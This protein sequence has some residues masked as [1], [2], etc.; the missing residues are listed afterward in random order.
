[1]RLLWGPLLAGVGPVGHGVRATGREVAKAD[2]R[3]GGTRAQEPTVLVRSPSNS[4][5][6]ASEINMRVQQLR[7]FGADRELLPDQ[8]LPALGAGADLTAADR[9]GSPSPNGTLHVDEDH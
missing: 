7:A 3:E 6:S 2:E 5:A 1:M 8:A 4:E 9:S